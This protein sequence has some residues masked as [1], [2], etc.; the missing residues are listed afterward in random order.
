MIVKT[1]RANYELYKTFNKAELS[2]QFEKKSFALIC[3]DFQGTLI[4]FQK[5]SINN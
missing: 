3:Y 4:S 2:Q 5:W 1:S